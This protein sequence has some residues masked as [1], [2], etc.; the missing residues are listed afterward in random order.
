MNQ[1]QE[2]ENDVSDNGSES[3]AKETNSAEVLRHIRTHVEHCYTVD[4]T[5]CWLEKPWQE[6][7]A[8]TT[9]G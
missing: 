9:L 5:G 7:A 4:T 2:A 1:Q 6:A 8:A 3:G